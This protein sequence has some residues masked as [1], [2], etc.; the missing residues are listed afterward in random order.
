MSDCGHVFSVLVD[1]TLKQVGRASSSIRQ[2]QSGRTAQIIVRPQ[3]LFSIVC[4]YSM[5]SYTVLLVL[6]LVHICTSK[7]PSGFLRSVNNSKADSESC[8]P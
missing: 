7:K 3:H 2:H 6:C 4:D 5:V 8:G 1:L